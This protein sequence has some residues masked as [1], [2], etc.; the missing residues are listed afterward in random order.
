[1]KQGI[2]DCGSFRHFFNPSRSN[3]LLARAIGVLAVLGA[4]FLSLALA[5]CGQADE[6]DANGESDNQTQGTQTSASSE[7]TSLTLLAVGDNLVESRE[8][9]AAENGEGYD[10]SSVFADTKEDIQAADIA[11]INQET[12]LVSGE[13]STY[14]DPFGTP[15]QGMTEAI[16]E[17]GFDVVLNASNHAF[18][19]GVEPLKESLAYWKET[20][21]HITQLGAHLNQEDADTIAVAEENGIKVAMLNYVYGLNDSQEDLMA[22]EPYLIDFLDKDRVKSDISRAREISDF[23]VVFAHMG[24][25]N[26]FYPSKKAQEWAKLFADA[27]ADL[28][29]GAHPHV[30][31]PVEWVKGKK[32][33]KMLAYYSLGNFVSHQL[34]HYRIFGAMAKVQIVKDAEGTH[35]GEYSM[36]PL[37]T[38]SDKEGNPVRVYKLADYTQ[39]LCDQQ[40]AKGLTL[41]ELEGLYT[42]ITGR[43]VEG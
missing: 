27:G 35:V 10:F 2:A 5:G 6:T 12:P 38:H 41:Y 40:E 3:S 32:G 25:S 8:Y 9:E 33:H 36:I 30:V 1:M 11:V 24:K 34:Q 20:Y 39:E 42:G 28:M 43:K 31:Q 7:S 21:P 15:R 13:P 26:V 23:V 18:D 19:R 22:D 16:N 14:P 29:I 4:L 37:V 17:A